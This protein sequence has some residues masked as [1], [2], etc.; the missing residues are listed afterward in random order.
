MGK[1]TGIITV[2][3]ATSVLVTA[4]SKYFPPD[5]GRFIAQTANAE[6]VAQIESDA[7]ILGL[8]PLWKQGQTEI[9]RVTIRGGLGITKESL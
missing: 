7:R 9:Y 6:T 8:S 1:R 4:C 5:T 2:I 3:F